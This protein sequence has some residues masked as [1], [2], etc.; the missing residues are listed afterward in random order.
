VFDI[1]QYR[2]Y[3]GQ[4]PGW[5]CEPVEM[6]LRRTAV[7]GQAIL[8]DGRLELLAKPFE[9]DELFD[10]AARLSTCRD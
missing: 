8:E 10:A 7:E 5:H 9:L 1:E 2:P 3:I 4:Q 6:E